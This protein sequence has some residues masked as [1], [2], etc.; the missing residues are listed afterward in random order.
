M[1]IKFHCLWSDQD[2]DNSAA[3]ISKNYQQ[4]VKNAYEVPLYNIPC[5]A[6]LRVCS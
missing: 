2:L 6:E 4:A 1:D 5:G 3:E